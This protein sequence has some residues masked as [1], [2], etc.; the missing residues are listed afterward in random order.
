VIA[1]TAAMLFQSL[2]SPCIVY[3]YQW[4]S[5]DLDF[6]DRDM[7]E[8]S[9]RDRDRDFIKNSESRDLNFETE[10]ETPAFK[11]FAF[12]RFFRKNVVMTSE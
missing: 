2:A 1:V 10:S 3:A 11:I 9:R 12:C 5:P 7:V 8:I 6:R 4:C